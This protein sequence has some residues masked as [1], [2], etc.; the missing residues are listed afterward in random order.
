VVEERTA[1]YLELI[2]IL[3]K[4][5]FSLFPLPKLRGKLEMKL[6]ASTKMLLFGTGAGMAWLLSASPSMAAET[7]V[8]EESR[9]LLDL[10]LGGMVFMSMIA[11]VAGLAIA[12]RSIERFQEP[13]F[14][15][16]MEPVRILVLGLL[17][18]AAVHWIFGIGG[19]V[20]LTAVISS[21]LLLMIELLYAATAHAKTE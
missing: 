16:I 10:A 15:A 2:G 13:A 20:T 14:P 11:S 9:V 4:K 18:A 7:T 1:G 6:A 12:V 21:T 19:Q 3:S 17:A 8:L 5:R